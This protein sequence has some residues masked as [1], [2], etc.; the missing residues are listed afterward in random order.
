MGYKDLSAELRNVLKA[1]GITYKDVAI[2]MGMSE[3]GVKKLLT[4]KDI[5]FNKL[6]DIL[7]I[8]K[9]DLKTLLGVTDDESKRYIKL[10]KEQENF[11][12]S[13]IQHYNFIVHLQHFE[14]D[15]KKLKK[16]NPKLSQTKIEKY[17]MDLEAYGLIKRDGVSIQSELVNGF[18]YGK[19]LEEATLKNTNTVFFKKME[20]IDSEKK[21][22]SVFYGI[23][24]FALSHK[25]LIEFRTA[26]KS[27][28]VEFSE[29]SIR[30]SKIYAKRDL[31]DIG[32]LQTS[33]PLTLNE[34]YPIG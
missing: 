28:L 8:A 2:E 4:S 7:K 9:L 18:R 32:F 16:A 1:R 30:E 15:I 29:R 19:K 22:S 26:Q 34:L 5:S 24:K 21:N 6:E 27:L 25:S 3:S 20:Q 23:G 14:M 11:L 33:V 13:N 17:L 10:T 31:V 12:I